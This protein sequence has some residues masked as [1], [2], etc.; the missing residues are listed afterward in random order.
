MSNQQSEASISL[1]GTTHPLSRKLKKVIFEIPEVQYENMT[2][3]AKSLQ[4]KNVS[5]MM[6][7]SLGMHLD[8]VFDELLSDPMKTSSQ[9]RM[10]ERLLSNHMFHRTCSDAKI[11]F[12][13]SHVLE[14]ITY[15][16]H[17]PQWLKLLMKNEHSR[18]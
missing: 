16:G 18:L 1:G 12:S 15:D 4:F 9:K 14:Q 11:T 13:T 17:T 7:H 3:I 2:L 8:R 10:I 5:E 6:L